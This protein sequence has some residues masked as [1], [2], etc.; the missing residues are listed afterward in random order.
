MAT[1]HT[2]LVSS[3]AAFVMQL[4]CRQE[5]GARFSFYHLHLTSKEVIQFGGF[6]QRWISL[7]A[8]IDYFVE[9]L[10]E[11]F[12]KYPVYVTSVLS[13]GTMRTLLA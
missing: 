2:R 1:A 4:D 5:L 9:I 13:H 8:Q 6:R 3:S 7:S 10:L 11:W 12:I